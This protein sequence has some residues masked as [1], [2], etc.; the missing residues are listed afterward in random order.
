MDYI[1][2]KAKSTAK[3]AG[4]R[5]GEKLIRKI[6]GDQTRDQQ[7][8]D[9]QFSFDKQVA[10]SEKFKKDLQR[11]ETILKEVR[12]AAK[13]LNDIVADFF[14]EFW[15][16]T[17]EFQMCLQDQETLW[18]DLLRLVHKV[19][20]PLR[21][22]Q[23]QFV[24]I[25]ERIQKRENKLMDYDICKRS[26]EKAYNS[27]KS[28]GNKIQKLEDAFDDA[29]KEYQ[30]LNEEL[31]YDLP[32]VLESRGSFVKEAFMNL[33]FAHETFSSETFKVSR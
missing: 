30:M 2:D 33:F 4:K 15:P 25:K 11:Y 7:F 32:P 13:G 20:D 6:G 16:G 24:D 23:L 19:N 10:Q 3:K 14:E 27:D 1:A 26:L 8:D 28:S 9:L 5:A 21:R 12:K 31:M 22:Y 18:N 29:E 17:K